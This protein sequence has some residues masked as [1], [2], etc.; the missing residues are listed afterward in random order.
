M[1]LSVDFLKLLVEFHLI[2]TVI[3]AHF[4]QSFQLS[5]FICGPGVGVVVLV[6]VSKR[7]LKGLL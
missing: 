3:F 2:L 4:G 1:L 5:G 7:R 6:G